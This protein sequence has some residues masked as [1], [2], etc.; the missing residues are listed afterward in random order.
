MHWSY[1]KTTDFS[2]E[3]MRCAYRQL[4]P[5]RKARIDRLRRREDRERSLS[6]ELLVYRL[7]KK[8]WNIPS[9]E[10]HSRET[11][12][13]YLSDCNLHVSIS[14]CDDVVACAISEEPVGIDA[15][16][17][18]PIHV[19]ICRRVCTPEELEYVS[20]NGTLPKGDLCRDPEVLQRF[21]EIWTAKEAYFKKCG[22]GI[23]DLKS[24]N[25]LPLKREMHVIDDCVIQIL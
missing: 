22:T 5:S 4:S 6:A 14:H 19:N 17:I 3:D 2:E 9:A 15:E 10:L 20:G 25:V 1:C 7:L 24:V 8:Y 11:G 13:P 18:R 21:F 12:E 16:R 23:T